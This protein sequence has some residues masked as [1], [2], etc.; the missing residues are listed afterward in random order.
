MK[1]G[2][3]LQ[4]KN[5]TKN[6][7]A[8]Q[9]HTCAHTLVQ[10]TAPSTLAATV[11][12]IPRPALPL[13]NRQLLGFGLV[14]F[15]IWTVDKKTPAP[16]I[17][18][19]VAIQTWLLDEI[20]SHNAHSSAFCRADPQTYR[21]AQKNTQWC[22]VKILGPRTYA[23]SDFHTSLAHTNNPPTHKIVNGFHRVLSFVNSYFPSGGFLSFPCR[24]F[25]FW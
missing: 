1:C 13:W 17:D 23:A 9:P 11:R 10:V 2:H 16:S 12:S 14:L 4:K 7:S 3:Q 8:G 20:D 22:S 15:L 5:L 6:D 19:T 18:L 24:Y 25:L 21:K